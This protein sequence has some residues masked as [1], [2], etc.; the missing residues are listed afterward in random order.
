MATRAHPVA[1]GFQCAISRRTGTVDPDRGP[2]GTTRCCTTVPPLAG[3]CGEPRAFGQHFARVGKGHS[4]K[5]G[6]GEVAASLSCTTEGAGDA[7][8]A[9]DTQALPQFA[10]N[11]ERLQ[12][13][14]RGVAELAQIRDVGVE[15]VPDHLSGA[16]R[17][18]QCAVSR[19]RGNAD[20]VVEIAQQGLGQ[21]DLRGGVTARRRRPDS[22]VPLSTR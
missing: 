20:L 8:V 14:I 7:V 2:A 15:V 22:T 9:D 19:V 11:S 5:D 18:K 16:H 17:A 12:H 4:S 6:W 21:C 3:I 1:A 10:L 13:D